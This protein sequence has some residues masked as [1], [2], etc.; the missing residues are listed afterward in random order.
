MQGR[1][2]IIN[3][4]L[5]SQWI[6]YWWNRKPA[7]TIPRSHEID[8]REE[9]RESE[10]PCSNIHGHP[11]KQWHYQIENRRLIYVIRRIASRVLPLSGWEVSWLHLHGR[12]ALRHGMQLPAGYFW[13]AV[14]KPCSLPAWYATTVYSTFG[15]TLCIFSHFQGEAGR[16]WPKM[17]SYLAVRW[18]QDTARERSRKRKLRS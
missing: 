18:L 15:G 3:K 4:L 1:G 14:Y 8:Q 12:H 16:H 11:H 17:D 9:R 13:V 6:R 7:P 2:P 10:D 5:L